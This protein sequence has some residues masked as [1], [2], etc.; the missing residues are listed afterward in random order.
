MYKTFIKKTDGFEVTIE[1][2]TRP[3][4][5]SMNYPGYR[6][7]YHFASDKYT[8]IILEP[9]YLKKG[10]DFAAKEL[11]VDGYIE[12]ESPQP[13]TMNMI[14]NFPNSEQINELCEHLSESA[15]V[16]FTAAF[17]NALSDSDNALAHKAK[18]NKH[19]TDHYR[20]TGTHIPKRQSDLTRGHIV[21]VAGK[22]AILNASP[23]EFNCNVFQ[24]LESSLSESDKVRKIFNY[25][26]NSIEVTKQ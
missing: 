25:M 9:D 14:I 4:N 10:I 18:A 26:S 11:P 2:E 5:V 1:T 3:D 24:I 13:V 6:I 21:N 8:E 23:Y 19:K 16:A 20:A 15:F 22:S 17:K 7:K 12:S